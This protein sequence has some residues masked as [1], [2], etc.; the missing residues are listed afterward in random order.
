LTEQLGRAQELLYAAIESGTLVNDE[1][2]TLA[3][4]LG[5]AVTEAP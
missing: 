4:G 1:V 3:T 5:L 2:R